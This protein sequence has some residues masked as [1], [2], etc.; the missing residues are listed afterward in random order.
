[1]SVNDDAS[2]KIR[3]QR[4]YN[5]ESRHFKASLPSLANLIFPRFHYLFLFI[6]KYH[7]LPG[8]SR[9]RTETATMRETRF[10]RTRVT[11]WHSH[12]YQSSPQAFLLFPHYLA[13]RCNS[14]CLTHFINHE[15]RDL[16][17]KKIYD[18][19]FTRDRE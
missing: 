4:P 14:S 17:P 9:S 19:K 12:T 15:L 13:R 1:M 18:S 10:R 16:K 3:R 8:M 5:C 11:K 7:N 6:T 2:K